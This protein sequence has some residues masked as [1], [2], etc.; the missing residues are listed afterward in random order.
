VP[1]AIDLDLLGE[2]LRRCR[3]TMQ[4]PLRTVSEKTGVSVATLSRIERKEA[5]GIESGTLLAITE[6]MGVP[7]EELI[8]RPMVHDTRNTPDVVELHLR[9]DRNLDKQ[10]ATALAKMFRAAYEALSK[11]VEEEK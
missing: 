3:E 1:E 6:W 9:A 10:T 5:K 4:V 8:E 2:R 11:N 7:V